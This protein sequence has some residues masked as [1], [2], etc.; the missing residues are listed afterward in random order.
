[1]TTVKLITL[2]KPRSPT[3]EA[4][5]RLAANLLL[6]HRNE[7]LHA[8]VMT[9]PS[10]EIGK[11]HAIANLAVILAQFGKRIILVDADLHKPSQHEI[12]GI[13]QQPGLTAMLL[14]HFTEPPLCN[15]D[16]ENLL[17]LPS[18]ILPSI[19]ANVIGS[20]NMIV[21]IEEIKNFCDIVLFDAPPVLPVTDALLL[22]LNLDGIVMVLRAGVTHRS[23]A[24]RAKELI[25]QLRIRNLGAVLTNTD[26][27]RRLATYG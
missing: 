11:S 8:L 19:P 13:P 5:R 25:D 4:Y 16:I 18:G 22:A 2:T 7:P 23:H 20:P 1:M 12:W 27:D 21:F 10:S 6:S 14:Q 9:S 15:T 26:L 17:V 24:E 3:S